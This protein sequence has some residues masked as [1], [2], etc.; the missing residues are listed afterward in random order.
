MN[1]YSNKNIIIFGLGITGLSCIDFFISRKVIPKIIDTRKNPPNINKIP[2]NI[3]YYIG[4]ININWL[5]KADLIIISPGITDYVKIIK[6]YINKNTKIISDLDL[7]CQET[8]VPII[9]IT[10]SNGKSTVTSLLGEMAKQANIKVGIGGNIGIPVLT[11]L[12]KKYELYVIEISSFQ[13]EIIMNARFLAVVILNITP[14]HLDKYPKGFVEYQ[15]TKLKIYKYA[16]FFVINQN[17]PLIWPSKNYNYNSYITY[18]IN[19]GKYQLNT[20]RN[21]IEINNQCIIKISQIRLIGQHN[22]LNILASLALANLAE[23]PLSAILQTLK[24]Y[25]G[26]PHR[27]QLIHN[28]NNVQWINDSKSTNIGSTIA[29]INNLHD[30]TGTIYLLLGG[31]SKETNIT[32][33]KPHILKQ[34]IILYCFGK[35]GKKFIIL[36][37]NSMFFQTLEECI[38]NISKNIRSGDIVLLSPAC[39]SFDQFK[40]FE[41]RGR[42]FTRLAYKLG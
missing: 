22:Y 27:Y 30:I 25:N 26:L 33:L 38:K 16:K 8:K 35:D 11:L 29:A 31:D 12:K 36:K 14:D 21:Q 10:G 24:T 37:K 23:I 20:K 28:K 17:D 7:F 6:K 4:G 18:G 32:L 34:N 40:N 5:S 39:A 13:L 19:S 42:L 3:E 41:E 1:I 9:A 2:S 15:K